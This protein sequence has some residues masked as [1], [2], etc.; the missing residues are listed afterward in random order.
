MRK[1]RYMLLAAA[2]AAVMSVSGCYFFPEEEAILDPPTIAPDEV[3]YSTFTARRRTIENILTVTGYVKSR[4]ERECYFTEYTGRIKNV[5]VRPGD[6]VEEGDIIA[7]MNVGEAE[8]LRKIQDLKVQAARLKYSSTGAE[9][10][11]L[12]L[13]IEKNTLEMYE[14]QCKGAKIYAPMSGQVSYVF[15]INP[16]TEFDPYKVIARVVDP[17]DLF[18]AAS[19][20]GDARAFNVGDE[21]T[22]D[23]GDRTFRAKISYT[24]KEA[25][26]DG[27]D[28]TKVLY[29]EF[30]G[31]KPATAL[32]GT[33]ADIRKVKARAENAVVIPKNLVKTD[34]DR[35]FVQVYENGGKIEKDIVVGITNA[36]EAEIVSGLE[37]GDAVIM[38]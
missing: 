15:R 7:E 6:T 3:A 31:E 16:G 22:V 32:M 30:V 12:Q 17:D 38:R 18:A 2:L 21:V 11:R 20:D 26:E 14:A 28:D 13:E 25:K 9:A 24:P 36:T 19:Y 1:T 33:L 10:D 8:Y 4:T 23:V 27:L 5:Y 37:E 35:T 29:A 34:G